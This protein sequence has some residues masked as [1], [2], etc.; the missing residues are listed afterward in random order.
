MILFNTIYFII[1]DSLQEIKF[2]GAIETS[3]VSPPSLFNCQIIS[4]A[5][6][7]VS[8]LTMSQRANCHRMV[9]NYASA[10]KSCGECPDNE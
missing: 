7:T 1:T 10:T 5:M 3:P 6:V 9:S 4:L 2:V 8:I